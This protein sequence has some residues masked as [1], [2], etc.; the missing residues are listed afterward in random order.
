[1]EFAARGLAAILLLR[2]MEWMDAGVLDRRSFG[3][4]FLF[5]TFL[6]YF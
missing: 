2:L 6:N 4:F 3:A 5:L 1:V